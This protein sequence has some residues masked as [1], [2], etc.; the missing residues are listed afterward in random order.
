MNEIS[1]RVV[2]AAMG[3]GTKARIGGAGSLQRSISTSTVPELGPWPS[4]E[5]PWSRVSM[6]ALPWAQSV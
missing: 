5:V 2:A 3:G 6:L 4:F 1:Q